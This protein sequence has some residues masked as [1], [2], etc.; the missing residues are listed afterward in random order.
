MKTFELKRKS[1]HYL[2]AN[3]G[4]DR[5]C[6][7]SDICT[8]IRSVMIGA[9][10]FAAVLAVGLFFAGCSLFAIGNLFSWLFLGYE[11]AQVTI[12]M[13]II[14]FAFLCLIT[15]LLV[16]EKVQDIMRDSEP[17]FVHLVYHSWKD[18]FCAKVE[19]K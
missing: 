18:K 11:L 1:W 8:Y 15:Y 19:F 6:L 3:F 2:L 14:Y 9:F 7:E 13:G 17:G 4:S 10:W 12:T 5:V 16:S